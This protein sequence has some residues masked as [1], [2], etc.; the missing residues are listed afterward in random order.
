[1]KKLFL[2]F[3]LS[4]CVAAPALSQ[5]SVNINSDIPG[6]IHQAQVLAQW[7]SQYGQMATQITQLKQQYDSLNGSRGLGTIMNKSALRDYLP[8]DWQKVY[9]SVRAGGYAGLSGSGKAVYDANKIYDACAYITDDAQRGA[10][11][12]R[13]VKPSQDKAFATDAYQ[14]AKSRIDQLDALMGKI[15]ETQDPKAIA[16]MQ[17]RIAAEQANI[18]NEQTKLQLYSMLATAEDRVQAQ[19]QRELNA[20]TWAARKGIK[21]N[22]IT[23]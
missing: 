14:A 6:E 13:A 15:N 23:F 18:Q 10:C 9:D 19:R 4:A 8:S 5:L 22:P 7:T 11:Q 17:A 12:A 21:V 16:E 3:A 1:M 2:G 20:R